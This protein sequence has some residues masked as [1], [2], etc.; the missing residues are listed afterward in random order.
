M[1]YLAEAEDLSPS[2]RRIN[3]IGVNKCDGNSLKV[4]QSTTVKIGRQ[5]KVLSRSI[6][7]TNHLIAT[8]SS[9]CALMLYLDNFRDI[10]F[11]SASNESIVVASN[12]YVV[13]TSNSNLGLAHF[14]EFFL[15]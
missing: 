10:H 8:F 1:V 6:T 5:D 15:D 11:R 4:I 3:V 7:S 9:G 12:D 13:G 2:H 14:T